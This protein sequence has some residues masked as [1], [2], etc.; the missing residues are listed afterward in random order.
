MG[1][2]NH[3]HKGSGGDY[4]CL[5]EIPEF[6]YVQNG[7]SQQRGLVY[8][9]EYQFNEVN[10]SPLEPLLDHDVPCAVCEVLHRGL[11]LMIPAKMSC[12]DGWTEE[13]HGYLMS[14]QYGSERSAQF[15]CLDH[16]PETIPNSHVSKDGALLYM[17][18]GR[19]S[20]GALPCDTYVDGYE[21]TCVV[22][23]K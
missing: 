7:N 19:C 12:P 20:E 23:T 10:G 21:L 1:G 3:N 9:A 22:C 6:D 14:E 2:S 16:D 4:L 15:I 11:H 13:Y 17:V 18:E 8:S 5:S